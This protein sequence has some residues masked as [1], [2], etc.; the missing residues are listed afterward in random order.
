[1]AKPTNRT[2]D[3]E[4]EPKASAPGS[5]A[6]LH[7][8]F[9]SRALEIGR[10]YKL[11]ADNHEDTLIRE[12]AREAI[13]EFRR[14]VKSFPLGS[15]EHAYMVNFHD[16]ALDYA[17]SIRRLDREL[18]EELR[19]ARRDRDSDERGVLSTVK[20]GAL[21][22]VA[23]HYLLIG[24]LFFFLAK[25]ITTPI[26]QQSAGL[27]RHAR[28]V[29]AGIGSIVLA[30]IAQGLLLSHRLGR[31][32]KRYD[33]RVW[34]ARRDWAHAHVEVHNLALSTVEHEWVQLTGGAA[35]LANLARLQI[36]AVYLGALSARPP[37]EA[38]ARKRLSTRLRE[39]AGLS[40][41][42]TED[43]GAASRVAFPLAGTEARPL[44]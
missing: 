39:A 1:M 40:V 9:P 27:E 21:L 3:E 20:H 28:E 22:K 24:G 34:R 25:S 18:D 14:L 43:E 36:R 17:A 41:Q 2:E 5:Q 12:H 33:L 35:P 31:V 29:A 30:F 7:S 16:S 13:D 38:P 42:P 23:F 11:V 8:F 15:R 10:M 44:P 26:D 6:D 19:M 4:G 32:R 37:R